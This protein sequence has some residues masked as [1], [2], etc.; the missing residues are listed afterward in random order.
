MDMTAEKARIAG[1]ISAVG[2][3]LLAISQLTLPDNVRAWVA[4]ALAVVTGAGVVLGVYQTP[5]HPI[6]P[7]AD[8][9]PPPLA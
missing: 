6:D 3:V 4:T 5:N 2:A 8:G 1:Y 9:Q 7:V